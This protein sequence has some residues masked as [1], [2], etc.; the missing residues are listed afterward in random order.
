MQVI[1]TLSTNKP[2]QFVKSG[3]VKQTVAALCKV[4]SEPDPEGYEEDS[5]DLPSNKLAS[6]A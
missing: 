3:L 4:C 2:K 1:E 5:D 6:Q